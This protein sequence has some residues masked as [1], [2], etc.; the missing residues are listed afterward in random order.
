MQSIKQSINR[1]V[2][3]G[4]CLLF[5]LVGLTSGCTTQESRPAPRSTTIEKNTTE[6]STVSTPS[7]ARK[8]AR[9]K[10][11]KDKVDKTSPPPS[12]EPNRSRQNEEAVPPDDT[13]KNARDRDGKTLTPMDQSSDS[14]DIEITRQIRKALM[15]DDT[16]ST[17]GK[18]I[19]IITIN[20]TAT[21]RGPVETADERSNI[22]NKANAV[23]NGKVD[24][25]LEVTAPR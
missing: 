4:S 21:L 13:G 24:N 18:N 20:G 7:P 16:L 17:L 15:A 14:N 3:I 11:N 8:P 6:K 19:K 12:A 10:E 25:Q 9:E 22:F 23:A 2:W 1:T 5:A